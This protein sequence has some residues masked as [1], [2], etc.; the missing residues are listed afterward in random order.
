MASS[1]RAPSPPSAPPRVTSLPIRA[2]APPPLP[3]AE[4]AASAASAGPS[5]AKKKL[6]R[7]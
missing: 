6:R 1:I 7:R 2:A 3:R 5:W 4:V